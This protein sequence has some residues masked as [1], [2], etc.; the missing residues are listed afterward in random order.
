MSS[1]VFVDN[2]TTVYASWLNDVN[3]SI[4]NLLGNGASIPVNKAALLVS[5]GAV[6]SISPA[7]TGIPTAP[8]ATIGTSTAQLATTAFVIANTGLTSASNIQTQAY[9]RAIITGTASAVISTQSPA[10]AGVKVIQ[11]VMTSANSTAATIASNGDV[12]KPTKQYDST[13]ALVNASW[14]S[15]ELCVWMDDGTNW[16]LTNPLLPAPAP[17]RNLLINGNFN[18]NQRLY[19]SGAATGGA[20][21][22]TL[23][24]WRVVTSGQNLAFST[25]GNGNV[26]TAPASG[27]EQVIEGANI[28]ST[29]YV[30]NWVGTATC[31]VDGTAKTKGQ[32][33]TLTPGTNSTVRFT[34]GTVSQAQLEQGS[35]PTPFE[36]RPY[37]AELSLCQRYY[38]TFDAA[39]GSAYPAGSSGANAFTAIH[40]P[41]PMRATPTFTYGTLVSNNNAAETITILSNKSCTYQVL[42]QAAAGL[43]NAVR[44]SNTASAEL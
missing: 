44:T 10:T 24:R 25:S 23:D 18:V 33:V 34:G 19:V 27:M 11:A 2:V 26:V 6:G 29:A 37:G 13:G 9:T 38:C 3:I 8:T 39:C 41:V 32:S 7:F 15:D 1:T 36:F 4:Y 30:I 5:I 40:F 14:A 12:G 22:Y 43:F 35:I 28:G 16:I 17:G 42:I 21:Q 31:T 20:N